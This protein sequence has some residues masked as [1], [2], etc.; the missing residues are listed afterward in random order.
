V[1]LAAKHQQLARQ[2]EGFADDHRMNSMA[3][4][5]FTSI[6][7]DEGTTFVFGSWI[8][9]F[10]GSGGFINQLANS[11]RPGASAAMTNSGR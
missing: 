6:V 8:C 4:F 10:D 1:G 9:V 5:N 2:I 3:S 7:P 11:R